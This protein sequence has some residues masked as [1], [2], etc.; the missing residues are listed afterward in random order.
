MAAAAPDVDG[1][2]VGDLV[3]TFDDVRS[4]AVAAVSGACGGAIWRRTIDFQ[5]EVPADAENVRP[6]RSNTIGRPIVV[7]VD[8]RGVGDVLVAIYRRYHYRVKEDSEDL[9]VLTIAALSGDDGELLWQT[10][11]ASL[12][13][14]DPIDYSRPWLLPRR[15][16]GVPLVLWFFDDKVQ[17]LR[18]TDGVAAA[19]PIET[20]E[21]Y[22]GEQFDWAYYFEGR[23]RRRAPCLLEREDDTWLIQRR[24]NRD[25]RYTIGLS[26]ISLTD[27][28]PKWTCNFDAPL[29]DTPPEWTSWPYDWPLAAAISL[30]SPNQDL[31]LPYREPIPRNE[32][33]LGI[34]RR[35]GRTGKRIW[36]SPVFRI[37]AYSY[38][39]ETP[40]NR[41]LV[42]ADLTGDG[43][44]EVFVARKIEGTR[45]VAV[46][47]LSGADG[48]V[49]WQR[50]FD[51]G[52]SVTGQGGVARMF[53]WQSDG[54]GPL[55]AVPYDEEMN[56]FGVSVGDARVWFLDPASGE[57]RHTLRG[58]TDLRP[59]DLDGDGGQDL[60]GFRPHR[61]TNPS[62]NEPGGR[63]FA[64]RGAPP[65]SLRM[66]GEWRPLAD[67]DGDGVVDLF[68][69][70][71]V[72]SGAS[73][74]EIW[75][76]GEVP[77]PPESGRWPLVDT[78]VPDADLDGDGTPD[79]L[80]SIVDQTA[81]NDERAA[82]MA[83]SGRDGHTLWRADTLG[84]REVNSPETNDLIPSNRLVV[85]R[86]VDGD[87]DVELVYVHRVSSEDGGGWRL[88]ALSGRDGRLLWQRVVSDE[89]ADYSL[90]EPRT[91]RLANGRTAIAVL[92]L[93]SPLQ[94]E[95]VDAANGR[96][97]ATTDLAGNS[98]WFSS[99]YLPVL[100]EGDASSFGGGV[101]VCGELPVRPS[102]GDEQ[103]TVIAISETGERRW[104]WTAPR[105]SGRFPSGR[106]ASATPQIADLN[107]GQP[108]VYFCFRE[109]KNQFKRPLVIV[110]LDGEGNR[111][112]GYVV[113]DADVERRFEMATL[114]GLRLA[115]GKRGLAVLHGGELLAFTSTLEKPAWKRAA[116]S[117]EGGYSILAT[118][119]RG[120][121]RADLLA[122]ADGHEVIGVD[123]ES[124]QMV[125]RCRGPGPAIRMLEA[126]ERGAL[127]RIAFS[128]GESV[129]VRG[130][131]AT[132]S[133]GTI[134]PLTKPA[135][136]RVRSAWAQRPL[137]WTGRGAISAVLEI[138]ATCLALALI[139]WLLWR[140]RWI[141][142]LAFTTL[143]LSAAAMAGGFWIY[144][145]GQLMHPDQS[146]SWAQWYEVIGIVAL[147]LIGILT[148]AATIRFALWAFLSGR[149]LA[150]SGR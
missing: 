53:W 3:V 39:D 55:L 11:V 76:T 145:D 30:G 17:R 16:G 77:P 130:A 10:P 20:A 83:I 125:W 9:T 136:V 120:K 99:G 141:V 89:T 27:G 100:A 2:G 56:R 60:L 138:S 68:R 146:Y 117:G 49:L 82:L 35:D 71:S 66:L 43:R 18:L 124:G 115:D 121:H 52:L 140:R 150:P 129:V 37:E 79:L 94:L 143:W 41:I 133:G 54:E 63:L 132:T 139:C 92:R 12:P 47:A 19:E 104:K 32:S 42:G 128:D 111:T 142:A 131:E 119:A 14:W 78:T 135:T 84:I 118:M 38:S 59:V 103:P 113:V 127:P 36:R 149:R 147:W 116:A 101:V 28:K 48:R 105:G 70:G 108:G 90:V 107:D 62:Q 102:S 51:K 123:A 114:H 110:G 109:G 46:A 148:V 75:S 44:R 106:P 25:D 4:P 5:P 95:L 134:R 98:G 22:G 69:R 6:Q 126:G 26:A 93:G 61:F 13:G 112:A 91:M 21:K 29:R 67:F 8:G 31:L 144:R 87:G 137:P 24:P 58:V 57:V 65:E 34:E 72:V 74:A 85:S 80:L 45:R 97:L 81:Q 96:S 50:Q 7:D 86:D 88:S 40:I 122:L 23:E 33:W 15:I 73:G 1:D 64:Y